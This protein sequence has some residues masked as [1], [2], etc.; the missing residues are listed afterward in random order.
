M[1]ERSSEEDWEEGRRAVVRRIPEEGG[2]EVVRRMEKEREVVRRR[3]ERKEGERQWVGGRGSKK[4]RARREISREEATKQMNS[5]DPP[6]GKQFHYVY[7]CRSSY[8]FCIHFP[9]FL[10]LSV[11]LV[12]FDHIYYHYNI[13]GIFTILYNIVSS[14]SGLSILGCTFGF[15]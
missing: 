15:L 9:T 3:I 8:H 12:L 4:R 13:W 5:M 1:R 10:R 2:R 6:R 7:Y 14:F 11:R